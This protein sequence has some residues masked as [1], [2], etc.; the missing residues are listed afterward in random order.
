MDTHARRHAD[1]G[2]TGGGSRRSKGHRTRENSERL[3]ERFTRDGEKRERLSLRRKGHRTEM[4]KALSF[5]KTSLSLFSF[6]ER[7]FPLSF[8]RRKS[9]RAPSHRPFSFVFPPSFRH[10]SY[11]SALWV[12]LNLKLPPIC[13]SSSD[14]I[15]RCR[16]TTIG[17]FS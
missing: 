6:A 10:I 13:G 4:V 8:A 9:E 14:V 1:C 15:K 12:A 7:L 16:E 3:R 17:S 5:V 11:S 2:V